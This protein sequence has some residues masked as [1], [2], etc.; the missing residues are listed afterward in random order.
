MWTESAKMVT[1]TQGG[2]D[3]QLKS[4][5]LIKKDDPGV[6]SIECTINEYSFQ[7]TLYDTGSD[8]NIVAAVTYQLLHGTMPL[9]PTY[10]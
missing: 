10:I 7:K 2:Q 4:H 8:V 9:Q 5:F 1:A 3:R 6:P